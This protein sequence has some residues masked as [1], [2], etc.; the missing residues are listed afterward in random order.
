MIPT[1]IIL[2]T[3]VLGLSYAYINKKQTIIKKTQ[4]VKTEKNK[5]IYID[6]EDDFLQQM[7]PH[8]QVA[9]DICEDYIKKTTD[10]NMMY[11]C[12][13]IMWQ[14]GYEIFIMKNIMNKLEIS[15]DPIKSK[16]AYMKSVFQFYEPEVDNP[17]LGHISLSTFTSRPIMTDKQFMTNMIAHHQMAVNMCK[18][19]LEHTS[20]NIIIDLCYDIIKEETKE[21]SQMQHTMCSKTIFKYDSCLLK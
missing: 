10:P 2:S 4:S 14:Q 13:H 5:P 21:I 19:M 9:I 20:N 6:K 8:H 7:I 11:L 17:N 1:I 18:S 16:T 15:Y 3:L 12:R